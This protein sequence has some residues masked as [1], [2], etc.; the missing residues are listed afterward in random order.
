M[1]ALHLVAKN[2]QS[3]ISTRQYSL[4]TQPGTELSL[5]LLNSRKAKKAREVVLTVIDEEG[6]TN[7][8]AGFLW[9]HTEAPDVSG[10]RT[11]MEAAPVALAFFL[12]REVSSERWRQDTKYRTGIRRRC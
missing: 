8:P 3:G 2:D 9:R 12:P 11:E 7:S 1:S 10:L 6:W 5:W 4:T